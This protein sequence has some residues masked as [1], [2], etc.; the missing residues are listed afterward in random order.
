MEE[1][2]EAWTRRR[3]RSIGQRRSVVS[4][5]V[6]GRFNVEEERG[7]DV[8]EEQGTGVEAHAKDVM[9]G[10]WRT[11]R[12]SRRQRVCGREITGL[13]FRG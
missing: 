9:E 6:P 11:R 3:R 8:E 2:G 4:M 7:A 1:L 13:E 5:E 12:R 10:A